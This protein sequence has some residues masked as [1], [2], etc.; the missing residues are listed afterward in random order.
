MYKK[1]RLSDLPF[2]ETVQ[3]ILSHYSRP[4]TCPAICCKMTDINLD[5][6]DLEILRRASK[7]KADQIKYCN[8]D[9]ESQYKIPPPCPFLET[10]KCS[11]YDWRPTMCRMF[12]FNVCNKPDLLLLFPCDMGTCIFE[13]YIEYSDKVLRK[14]LPSETIESFKQS[15]DSFLMKLSEGLPI[16]MLA[17]KI[18][19]LLPFKEYLRLRLE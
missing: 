13:D 18:D 17:F 9:G 5:E 12:P 6:K 15:H 7:Y 8:Y 10:D 3:E 11:V 1:R 4:S 2:F 14:P 16:P 19:S